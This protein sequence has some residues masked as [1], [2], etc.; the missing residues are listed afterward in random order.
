MKDLKEKNHELK[1]K[2]KKI[3]LG[4]DLPEIFSPGLQDS[5]LKRE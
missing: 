5:G 4:I 3:E 2:L 1:K